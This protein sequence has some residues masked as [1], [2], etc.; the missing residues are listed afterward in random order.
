MIVGRR[1]ENSFPPKPPLRA[2]AKIVLEVDKLQLL[3]DSPMLSFRLREG[4][5]LGFAGLVGSGRT[6]TAL[7]VIGADPAHVKEI[8]INGAAAK[9]SD[10]ADAL[11]AGVGIL[12]ESRKTEGL[13]T[14]FSIKQNISINNL[15]KY[16]SWS[17]FIDQRSE[18]RATADIMKRVGVKAPTMHTEV[19]T[20][21]GGNLISSELPEIVCM[22]D[23]VAVF[24]RPQKV[25]LH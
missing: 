6:E 16:R 25:T 5:I 2:D 9:L 4:E 13:I 19:A 22:C 14:D 17:F 18:A 20:L 12:P 11:R 21:S 23:R 15:G 7:A 1:I 10:P 3:K 24:R 8:R